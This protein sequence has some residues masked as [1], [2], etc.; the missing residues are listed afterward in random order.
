MACNVGGIERPIRIIL[1]VLLIG[2]GAFAGLPP[3]GTGVILAV[4]TIALA[5]GT[6]GYC[7]VWTL[8]GVNTCHLPS[9]YFSGTTQSPFAASCCSPPEEM[10]TFRA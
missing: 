5:T 3:I 10:C 6:I 8:F 7:P 4:G 1:G 2:I 9:V